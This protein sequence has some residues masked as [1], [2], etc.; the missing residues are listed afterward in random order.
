[1]STSALPSAQRLGSIEARR[2]PSEAGREFER[3]A[4]VALPLPHAARRTPHADAPS[5]L[6]AAP[7]Y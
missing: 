6:A 5:L 1:M 4:E 3:R 7:E 2:E